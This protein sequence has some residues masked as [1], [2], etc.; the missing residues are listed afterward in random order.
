MP[1]LYDVTKK[2]TWRF[3]HG[4]DCVFALCS[5]RCGCIES[6]GCILVLG[7]LCGVCLVRSERGDEEHGERQ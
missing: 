7:P 4:H 1:G 5:C 3:L 2:S 6:A